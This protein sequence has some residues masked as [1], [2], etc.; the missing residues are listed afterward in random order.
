MGIIFEEKTSRKI[1]NGKKAVFTLFAYTD[2]F[3]PDND[4]G[5]YTCTVRIVNEYNSLD[6][7]YY[8]LFLIKNFNEKHYKNFIRKF[9]N[10]IEY[11]DQ[12]NYKHDYIERR[13]SNIIDE[14]IGE[15]IAELNNLGLNTQ[16]SCQGTKDIWSDRPNKGD[17]HS[18]MAYIKFLEKLPSSFIHLAKECRYFDVGSQVI[19]SK[20]REYNIYFV[21]CMQELIDKWRIVI[22]KNRD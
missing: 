7:E 13:D 12:F 18:V 2:D 3:H 10:N 8:R 6:G 16:Y 19:S 9:S 20:K 11:R 1:E 15:V 21:K 5:C 17:G 22:L 4:E 14:E